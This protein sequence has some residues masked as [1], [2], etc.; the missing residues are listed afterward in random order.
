MLTRRTG[1]LEPGFSV[2]M[3]RALNRHQRLAEMLALATGRLE[4]CPTIEI[5]PA[6]SVEIAA[7]AGLPVQ[8]DGDAF[9]APS[10]RLEAA[11]SSASLLVP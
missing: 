3:S 2:V 7:T 10:I 8:V 4:Q 6:H 9:A 5:V 11:V 1:V